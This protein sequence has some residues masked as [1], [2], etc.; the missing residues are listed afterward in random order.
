MKNSFLCDI[1]SKGSLS[2]FFF[3]SSDVS[4]E[5]PKQFVS[6]S[7]SDENKAYSFDNVLVIISGTDDNESVKEL[8][9]DS[10]IICMTWSEDDRGTVCLI[11]GDDIG[12]IHF[13]SPE[14]ELVFS[15]NLTSSK[16]N[17]TNACMIIKYL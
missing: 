12:N 1:N 2:R 3:I 15:Y 7:S 4:D 14:A 9:F 17:F 13:V 8:E 5:N 10:N 16:L 11:I 6:A